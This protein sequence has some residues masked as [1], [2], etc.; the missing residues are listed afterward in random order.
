MYLNKELCVYEINT[1]HNTD[2]ATL[3]SLLK[4]AINIIIVL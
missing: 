1:E 4:L 2:C 3:S